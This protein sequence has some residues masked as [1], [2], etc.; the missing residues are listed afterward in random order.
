M[1]YTAI[2]LKCFN[3]WIWFETEECQS[4]TFT[5]IGKEGWGKGGAMIKELEVDL[6]L[7][8]GQFT[9]DTLQYV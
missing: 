7:L 2:K 3:Y 1:K 6:N 5:F 9:T 4:N 8:E